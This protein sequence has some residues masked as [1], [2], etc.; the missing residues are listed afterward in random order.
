[1]VPCQPATQ[2]YFN[3]FDQI[4]IR[5][6]RRDDNE[7]DVVIFSRASVRVLITRLQKMLQGG[8]Q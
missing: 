3:N 5:Q 1:L 2:T 8:P 7:D 6:E 4:V